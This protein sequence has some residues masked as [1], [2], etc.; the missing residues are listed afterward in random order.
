MYQYIDGNCA[1]SVNDWCAAGLTLTDFYND[2]KRGQLQVV[3][4]HKGGDTLIA[5]DSIRRADR[6]RAIELAYGKAQA[7][8][9]ELYALEAD[10][11]ARAYYAGYHRPARG[12]CWS[13]CGCAPSWT[14]GGQ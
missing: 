8:A 2:K 6:M 13:K 4:R 10:T 1:I 5:V 3:A 7:T 12:T 14:G 9:T 11:D